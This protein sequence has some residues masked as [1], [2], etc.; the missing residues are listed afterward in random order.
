MC[1]A[2]LFTC[3]KAQTDTTTSKLITSK[4]ARRANFYAELQRL[5]I[6]TAGLP[7]RCQPRSNVAA[8]EPD[9]TRPG[10]WRETAEART[11]CVF[12][13]AP[14]APRD[15]VACPDHRRQLDATPFEAHK[16][17]EAP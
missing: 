8:L 10:C 12:G 4:P 15:K 11:Q 1:A 2:V 17:L 13:S 7:P 16:K 14:L 6:M 3:R 9:P 5:N